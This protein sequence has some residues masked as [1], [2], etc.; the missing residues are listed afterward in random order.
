MVNKGEGSTLAQFQIPVAIDSETRVKVPD[1]LLVYFVDDWAVPVILVEVHGAKANSAR[2]KEG[3]DIL[4]KTEIQAA[5]SLTVGQKVIGVVIF[6]T[7]VKLFLFV[8]TEDAP[9]IMT[10]TL[11]IPL[12]VWPPVGNRAELS[13]AQGLSTLFYTLFLVGRRVSLCRSLQEAQKSQVRGRESFL[14]QGSF[15]TT[16][17][18]CTTSA[19]FASKLPELLNIWPRN[20]ICSESF[21]PLVNF[22]LFFFLKNVR[23]ELPTNRKLSKTFGHL[24]TAAQVVFVTHGTCT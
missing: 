17:T 19:Y 8:R 2:T 6:D 15:T 4:F 22:V 11:E 23:T 3:G 1:N 21:S 10:H 18:T 7:W 5:A 9:S 20:L 12:W 13:V 14:A 16:A 24:M